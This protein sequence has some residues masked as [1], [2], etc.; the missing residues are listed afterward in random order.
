MMNQFCW[1]KDKLAHVGTRNCLLHLLPHT[2]CQGPS[3]WALVYLYLL[4][5]Q[6]Q[7]T[8]LDLPWRCSAGCMGAESWSQ[9]LTEAA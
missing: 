4:S 1:D 6:L 9:V 8:T 2:H 5:A 7:I 3:L